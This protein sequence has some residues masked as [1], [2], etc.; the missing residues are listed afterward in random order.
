MSSKRGGRGGGNRG[1]LPRNVQVS[2]KISWLLRHG[3]EKEGLQLGPGGFIGVQDVLSNR[4]LRSLKVTFDELRAIVQDN[5]KQ[6]FTMVLKSSIDPN[7]AV[8]EDE[9]PTDI[10]T[11]TP[12]PSE[13]PKDYLIRANQ[14]H[15]LKVESEGLL[16]PITPE[17]A[18][19]NVVHGTTH[20]AWPL[21]VAS[22]GLKPMGRNHAHF[23]SGLP[24]GFKSLVEEDS[25]A[26]D[27]APVISG[28]RKSS[29]V[30]MF[31]DIA[32]AMEAGVN[33]WL[34]DNGVIL[35]EGNENGVIP[36][37]V[38]RRVEDRMG[39]GVLLEDGMIVKE[40]P[41]KWSAKRNDNS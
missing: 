41:E 18:P 20:S 4:N 33:F 9:D 28:M 21:I 8:L 3:A 12:L 15:S 35:S 36:L 37:E 2:K 5:E 6:R 16:K 11:Q 31:L 26:T 10:P 27:A 13:D 24:A 22:G 25:A 34:S 23:A 7:G 30:L 19:K 29:T 17:T 32:K 14:G 39:E 40:A 1:P 38:F